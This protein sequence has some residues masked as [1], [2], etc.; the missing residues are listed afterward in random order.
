MAHDAPTP[1]APPWGNPRSLTGETLS[2]GES[3]EHTASVRRN[4]DAAIAVSIV[5]WVAA[6]DIVGALRHHPLE[7]LALL[8]ATVL[9][10]SGYLLRRD[11]EQDRTGRL[12]WLA[13]GLSPLGDLGD[14]FG[15]SADGTRP[16]GEPIASW[17]LQLAHAAPRWSVVPIAAVVLTYP[18]RHLQ[19]RWHRWLLAAA[20]L[21]YV[22][23]PAAESLAYSHRRFNFSLVPYW[24]TVIPGG[25]AVRVP[26]AAVFF[27]GGTLVAVVGTVAVAS[28]WR[29]A[30]GPARPAIRSVALVGALLGIGLAAQQVSG[31]LGPQHLDVLSGKWETVSIAVTQTALAFAPLL[32]LLE[33]LRRRA[34]QMRVL[35]DLLAAGA[36]PSGVQQALS[37]ALADPALSLAFA[38]DGRWI[39][40]DPA[41]AADSWPTSGPKQGRVRQAISSRDGAALAL[42]DLSDA[43]SA[44]PALRR[45][46]LSAATVVLDNAR[47]QA[48]RAER[49]REVAQSRSRIVEAGLAERRRVERDLHDGAQQQLLAVAAT[50]ARATLTTD[51]AAL[52]TAVDDARAQLGAAL[53]ELRRLARG[54]HPAVL[55]QGG[56]PAALPT[57]TEA[58]PVDVVLDIQA[59][60]RRRRL[61]AAVESTAWFVAAES[62][63]NAVKHS[64]CTRLTI[65]L[66]LQHPGSAEQRLVLRITDDGAG[67]ALIRD[68]GGLAGLADR[69]KALGGNL[70]IESAPGAGT[71][72]EAVL[73]CAW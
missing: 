57:L 41:T 4:R 17:A 65:S 19:R 72:V 10:V 5:A 7:L 60:L 63:A 12:L 49:L 18:G 11:P 61:P 64:A 20:V 46:V 54:I 2:P 15:R 33:A 69:T 22:V 73:P 24:L 53:A 23:A 48:E 55:S 56:L 51:D 31:G 39:D 40:A 47:L 43:A 34:D 68:D 45:T 16:L 27:T 1:G 28:R 25:E 67:G 71:T 21:A 36:E 37:R 35:D 70:H 59:D 29:S 38:V 44:D 32:L 66:R 8:S 6:V 26:L 14:A 30:R 9:A 58:A 52:H 13:A 50:L 62:V 42:L 3:V